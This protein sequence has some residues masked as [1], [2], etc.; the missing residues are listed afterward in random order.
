MATVTTSAPA[1]MPPS[2]SIAGTGNVH[3]SRRN[4]ASI[5]NATAAPSGAAATNPGMVS[6][7]QSQTSSIDKTNYKELGSFMTDIFE[8]HQKYCLM[9]TDVV[10]MTFWRLFNNDKYRVRSD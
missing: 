7:Q 1:A 4:P 5:A 8:T 2:G 10:I 6:S 3:P 9:H